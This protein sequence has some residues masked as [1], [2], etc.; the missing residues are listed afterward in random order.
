[1]TIVTVVLGSCALPGM[2]DRLSKLARDESNVSGA[3]AVRRP[4]RK[5]WKV[6]PATRAT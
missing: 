4:H 6:A 1:M 2:E 3:W 5:H